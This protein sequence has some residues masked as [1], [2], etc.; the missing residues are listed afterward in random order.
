MA[1]AKTT[2]EPTTPP[3]PTPEPITKDFLVKAGQS[4]SY[5]NKLYFEG[6]KVPVKEGDEIG[7]EEVI[8]AIA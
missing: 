7:L 5:G 3:E 6:Q 8:E 2:T 1:T 4:L